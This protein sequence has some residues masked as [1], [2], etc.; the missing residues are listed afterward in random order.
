MTKKNK[1]TRE[2][3]SKVADL[4]KIH[5][6]D[7]ELD[8]YKGQLETA[9]DCSDTFNELDTKDTPVTSSSIG[10]AN[11]FREDE[12]E[13]SLSQ[14]DAIGNAANVEDGYIVVQRVVKK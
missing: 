1:L 3:V 2:D 8:K 5:I 7:K 12:P 4:I 10:F 14:E 11:V 13:N 9:L 6:P